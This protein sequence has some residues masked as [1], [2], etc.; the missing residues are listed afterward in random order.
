LANIRTVQ[1]SNGIKNPEEL[2]ERFPKIPVLGKYQTRGEAWSNNIHWPAPVARALPIVETKCLYE[3]DIAQRCNTCDHRDD[4]SPRHRRW[5]EHPAPTVDRSKYDESDWCTR[6]EIE[7][8]NLQS[9]ATCPDQRRNLLNGFPDPL[10][11]KTPSG[12]DSAH[13][14]AFRSM[15]QAHPAYVGDDGRYGIIWTCH[16]PRFWP[17]VAIAIRTLR[18]NLGCFLPVQV[19]YRSSCGSFDK[20]LVDGLNKIEFCDRDEMAARLKDSRLGFGD[21]NQGGW[22]VKT[23]AATHTTFAKF[24]LMDS[25]AMFVSDPT[26]IVPTAPFGYWID[27]WA[28]KDGRTNWQKYGFPK[29]N[30]L[31]EEIGQVQGGHLWIDKKA[32][33][34]FLCMAHQ[35]NEH[36][37]YW[38]SHSNDDQSVFRGALAYGA[39]PDYETFDDL[40]KGTWPENH[41][42]SSWIQ[43]AFVC[44]YKGKPFIRHDAQN[45]LFLDWLGA[46]DRI[47]MDKERLREY[48]RLILEM[49]R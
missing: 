42:Q 37:D 6:I 17:M 4:N 34:K 49:C 44:R 40:E 26:D 39:C 9:C 2:R 38:Y 11:P 29:E 10:H 15:L 31:S 13:V 28:W 8:L 14:A 35:A 22:Q 46:C 45:K 19:W 32:A 48:A 20:S 18:R 33:W 21:P 3:G 25:D 27:L 24:W 16:N 5:C 12:D 36:S 7:G 23:Y 43:R 41:G 47:P 1:K 30:R